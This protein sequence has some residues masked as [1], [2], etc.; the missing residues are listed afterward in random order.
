MIQLKT[1]DQDGNEYIR[2]AKPGVSL[3]EVEELMENE[4]VGGYATYAAV[5]V[6]GEIYSELEA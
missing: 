3:A 5:L 2:K 4:V 1:I 6:D